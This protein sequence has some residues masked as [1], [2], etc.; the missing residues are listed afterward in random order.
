MVLK[1]TINA[2]IQCMRVNF[3]HNISR[4]RVNN[5]LCVKISSLPLIFFLVLYCKNIAFCWFLLFIN[6]LSGVLWPCVMFFAENIVF[7][8]FYGNYTCFYLNEWINAFTCNSGLSNIR[9]LDAS[10]PRSDKSKWSGRDYLSH[11][12]YWLMALMCHRSVTL[13]CVA[14]CQMICKCQI[15]CWV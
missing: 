15:I 10:I 4:V 5:K 8:F 9:T 13:I 1:T 7:F 11:Q 3:A 14:I 6:C 2:C 12:F